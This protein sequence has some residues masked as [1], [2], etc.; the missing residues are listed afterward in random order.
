VEK[1][2]PLPQHRQVGEMISQGYPTNELARCN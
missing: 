1:R 2:V